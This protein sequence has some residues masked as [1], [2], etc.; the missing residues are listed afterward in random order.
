MCRSS[1]HASVMGSSSDHMSVMNALSGVPI[2]TPVAVVFGSND[3]SSVVEHHSE[4]LSAL[5][6]RE[7]RPNVK[8]GERN[9]SSAYV[10]KPKAVENGEL[11][12]ISKY[13]VQFVPDAKPQK[14]KKQ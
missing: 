7:S 14:R 3:A 8:S 6:Q 12:Y 2:A 11:R 9:T 4:V 13:L 5:Q 10:S 1:D